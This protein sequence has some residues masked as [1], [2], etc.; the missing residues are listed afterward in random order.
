MNIDSVLDMIMKIAAQNESDVF[1]LYD[2]KEMSGGPTR[3]LVSRAAKVSNTYT[4][5]E[6]QAFIYGILEGSPAQYT[7]DSLSTMEVVNY[8]YKESGNSEFKPSDF[9]DALT[10]R[11]IVDY[12]VSARGRSSTVQPK[13]QDTTIG[14]S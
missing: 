2:F 14:I 8:I 10:V 6:A 12:S 4:L 13:S 5:E 7:L 3:V 11:S 9:N 1:G